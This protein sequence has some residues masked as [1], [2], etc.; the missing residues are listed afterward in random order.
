MAL[1]L[2]PHWTGAWSNWARVQWELLGNLDAAI[3]KFNELIEGVEDVEY[4][5]YNL[6]EISI[7]QGDVQSAIKHFSK[8][9]SIP[10]AQR[11]RARI[12]Q[13]LGRGDEARI[14]WEEVLKRIPGDQEAQDA[15]ASL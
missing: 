15:L 9:P 5:Y 7:K 3:E 8:A 10:D 11:G 1:M 12:L 14:A 2:R 13:Q 4:S 6:G